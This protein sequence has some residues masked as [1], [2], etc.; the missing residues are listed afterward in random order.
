MNEE[1]VKVVRLEPMVVASFH[2]FGA[3]PEDMALEKMI[4]WAKPRFNL[5]GPD[6]P[7]IFGFNNPNPTAGS[8]NYGYEFWLEVPSGYGT[9][10]DAGTDEPVI[11]EF[12]GGLYAVMSTGPIT[13]PYRDIPAA[14]EKLV[15]WVEDSKYHGGRHVCLE[16]V[17]GMPGAPDWM[18]NLYA[19][20]SE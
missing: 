11:K 10:G 6:R 8:P 7:R 1:E 15:R 14:W 5:E 16:E 20:V 2:A 9:G 18:L 17:A 3:N 4:S 19:P 12:S 13:E